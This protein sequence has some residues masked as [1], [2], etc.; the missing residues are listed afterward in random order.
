MCLHTPPSP[1]TRALCRARCAPRL[2]ALG[3]LQE[4]GPSSLGASQK[5]HLRPANRP[6]KRFSIQNREKKTSPWPMY[7]VSIRPGSPAAGRVGGA[8]GRQGWGR[9]AGTPTQPRLGSASS[10]RPARVCSAGQLRNAPIYLMVSTGFMS[11]LL[12]VAFPKLSPGYKS[13][14]SRWLKGIN[15]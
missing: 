9:R 5:S 7:P 14:P 4:E 2:P 8:A 3:L 10:A 15:Q 6:L 12:M 13:P 11:C 1:Q